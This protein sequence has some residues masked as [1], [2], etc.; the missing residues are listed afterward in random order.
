MI[1]KQSRREKSRLIE[2]NDRRIVHYIFNPGQPTKISPF[3]RKFTKIIEGAEELAEFETEIKYGNQ[4][5]Y[6]NKQIDG[7]KQKYGD[8]PKY[9]NRQKYGTKIWE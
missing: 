7:N 3:T 1:S 6:G 8:E 5:N 2:S 4:Q 9:G